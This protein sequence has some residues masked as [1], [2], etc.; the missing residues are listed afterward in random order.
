M[1]SH[2]HK[3]TRASVYHDD[4][5]KIVAVVFH[6]PAGTPGPQAA[7]AAPKGTRQV[8]V[9]LAGE[10]AGLH[11]LDLHTKF[12]VDVSGGQPHLVRKGG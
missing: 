8:D 10:L 11:P 4:A 3:H 1:S 5:G 2:Q 12:R 9:E 6:A 7:V